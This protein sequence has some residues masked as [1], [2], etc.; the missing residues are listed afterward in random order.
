MIIDESLQTG[1]VI[2]GWPVT[3]HNVADAN[4]AQPLDCF[5]LRIACYGV[6]WFVGSA[7][8][9][10]LY[11]RWTTD[12]VVLSITL[13]LAALPVFFWADRS[14]EALSIGPI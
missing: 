7:A 13:Q 10:F 6:A 1:A 3:R 11:E 9:G 2:N 8:M 5:K 4:T 14:Q 12:L